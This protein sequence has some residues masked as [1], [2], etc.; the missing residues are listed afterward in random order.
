MGDLGV[1]QEGDD[2]TAQILENVIFKRQL[3]L[4]QKI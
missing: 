3:V 1:V 4:S 2:E